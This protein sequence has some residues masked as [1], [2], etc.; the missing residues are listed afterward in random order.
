MRLKPPFYLALCVMILGSLVACSGLQALDLI[1]PST[2]Y[3]LKSDI[4]YG[5]LPRQKLDVYVPD[6]PDAA[7][8]VIVFF[9]GGSWQMGNKNLYRFIGQSLASQGYTVVIADYRLYPDA[10]FPAYVEDAAKAF[11][12]THKHI[13]E[14]GG[15]TDKLFLAGHSAGAHLAM[16]LTLDDHY[17]KQAGV[18][19]SRI[20]GTI[21]IAGPYDF[22]P[23]TDPKLKELFSKVPLAKTQ[24]INY[25]A[26][27]EP[28][29]LLLHGAA[30]KSVWL[31]NSV[32]L[33]DKLEEL[34]NKVTIKVYPE[35]NHVQI[36]QALSVRFRSKAA[37][38]QDMT[39]FI[40]DINKTPSK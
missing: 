15:N 4:A 25:V 35:I 17:L 33:A 11:Q 23:L 12:W 6:Q 31:K 34:G 26:K 18:K 3:K 13:A 8:S 38:L 2:G 37:T 5:S 24:P 29:I 14:Y 9:Y 32:N 30:D 16:L 28:P 21:G 19:K 10:Y 39:D 7:H 40:T 27:H 1:T 36:V 22:L 20:K